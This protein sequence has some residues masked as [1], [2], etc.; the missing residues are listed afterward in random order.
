[1]KILSDERVDEILSGVSNKRIKTISVNK[2]KDMTEKEKIIAFA[3]F[4]REIREHKFSG[5]ELNIAWNW[6]LHEDIIFAHRVNFLIIIESMLLSAFVIGL[7]LTQDS[8]LFNY[9]V[10]LFG[11][12]GIIL[13]SI[14][15]YTCRVQERYTIKPLK[16]MIFYYWYKN[17]RNYRIIGTRF[18]SHDILSL[19]LPIFFLVIWVILL[20][21]AVLFRFV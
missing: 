14:I 11:I 8:V 2:K 7:S 1:M 16:Q 10:I 9:F 12:G 21:A 17:I 3:H 5:D 6:L 4:H 13:T 15:F 19:Y 18:S 20:A